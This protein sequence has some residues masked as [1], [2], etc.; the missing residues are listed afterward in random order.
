MLARTE[1]D[2]YED[3]AR[4]LNITYHD[5]L[6]YHFDLAGI[7]TNSY[8]ARNL[9]GRINKRAW[10]DLFI[11]VP[12]ATS[13]GLFIEIKRDGVR[14]F[15]RDGSISSNPHVQEQLETLLRLREQGYTAEFAVGLDEVVKIITEYLSTSVFKTT[16][17]RG[18]ELF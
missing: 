16:N 10:P 6:P 12:N 13:N 7:Y 2:I 18:T 1:N 17:N 8:K 11:P 5:R 15:K 14:V 3:V 9:Y 4:Y